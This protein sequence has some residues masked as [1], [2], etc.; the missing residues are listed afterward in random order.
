M[1]ILPDGTVVNLM[2]EA[3]HQHQHMLHFPPQ[4]CQLSTSHLQMRGPLIEQIARLLNADEAEADT[5]CVCPNNLVNAMVERHRLLDPTRPYRVPERHAR[6]FSH[7]LRHTY[8]Q[9]DKILGPKDFPSRESVVNSYS[10]GKRIHYTKCLLELAAWGLTHVL[11]FPAHVKWGERNARPRA[12]V[13]QAAKAQGQGN[14]G[15]PG[16]TRPG[17]PLLIPVLVESPV[18]RL[19][20]IAMHTLRNPDGTRQF[21]S[22]R[23]L[24]TRVKDIRTMFPAGWVCWSIDCSSYDGSQGDLANTERE[25]CYEWVRDRRYEHLKDLKIVFQSQFRLKVKA[26]G[27]TAE[28]H[29]NRA[30]GTAGT[31]VANKLVMIAALKHAMCVSYYAGQVKFYCDGD[32]TLIFVSPDA[33]QHESSWLRRLGLLGLDVIVENR[34]TRVEDIVFCRSKPVS[35][36]SNDAMLVK[37]PADAFKTMCAVVRHFKGNALSSYFSTMKDGYARLWAGV[38]VMSSL[39]DVFCSNGRVNAKLLD[40]DDFYRFG[41][42]SEASPVD[43]PITHEARASFADAFGISPDAQMRVEALCRQVGT[44]MPTLVD[45]YVSARTKKIEI[46]Y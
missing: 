6:G 36:G 16:S 33:A 29:G 38:P 19:Q 24:K 44:L 7:Q 32:D 41:G 9:M 20:E 35:F 25:I 43:V 40:S 45:D 10:G 42:S 23:S 30:S 17:E 12:I 1:L 3:R 31:S 13:P 26:E 11:F 39:S 18:R 4:A 34:A 22:G 21:A 5:P 14:P 27:L 2:V 8:R 15:S 37:R 28:V 46:T